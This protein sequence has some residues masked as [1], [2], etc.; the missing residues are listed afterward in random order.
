PA[1]TSCSGK[2]PSRFSRRLLQKIYQ[3]ERI[4]SENRVIPT[5]EVGAP[6]GGSVLDVRKHLHA[7]RAQPLYLLGIGILQAEQH[8]HGVML[9]GKVQVVFLIAPY[10]EQAGA[11]PRIDRMHRIDGSPV[12]RLEDE[13][14]LE[15][16][17]ANR[18]VDR[19]CEGHRVD[20]P[21][22]RPWHL[23]LAEEQM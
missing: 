23:R 20:L 21:L 2:D 13:A 5:S 9:P 8:A 15:T 1:L 22:V 11:N 14:I 17:L 12:E 6:A 18:D 10:A 3:P 19:P 16:I 7:R 4:V